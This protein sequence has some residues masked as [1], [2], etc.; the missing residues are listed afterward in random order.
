ML[1]ATV[2][3]Q[4]CRLVIP[5]A[6]SSPLKIKPAQLAAVGKKGMGSFEHSW[7]I[8]YILAEFLEWAPTGGF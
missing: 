8:I 1:T 2:K 4:S 6:E 3:K 5:K 7:Y